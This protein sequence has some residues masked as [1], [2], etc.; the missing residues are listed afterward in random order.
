MLSIKTKGLN[1]AFYHFF[2][3]G[4][5]FF[6]FGKH[7]SKK[8]DT[9]QKIPDNKRQKVPDSTGSGNRICSLVKKETG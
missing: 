9:I 4:T 5:H 6:F 2:W 7:N 1:Y 8:T 3:F